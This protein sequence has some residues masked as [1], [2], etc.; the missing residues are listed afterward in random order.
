MEVAST[1][2]KD[3]FKLSLYEYYIV[4][5]LYF[6]FQANKYIFYKKNAI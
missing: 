2:S 1:D 4:K 5:V 3:M 6:D